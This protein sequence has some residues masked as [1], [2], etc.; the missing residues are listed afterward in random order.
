MKGTNLLAALLMLLAATACLG[1]TGYLVAQTHEQAIGVV[2][3][4]LSSPD[5]AAACARAASALGFEV[6]RRGAEVEIAQRRLAAPE[7]QYA[8]ASA[9]ILACTDYAL[10][11]FC[12]GEG[13]GEHQLNLVLRRAN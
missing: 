6:L 5:T 7:R 11:G 12:A 9:V 1:A 3:G 8:Q 13:C 4:R 10:E 2:E